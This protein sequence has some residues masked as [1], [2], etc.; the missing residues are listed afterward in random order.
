MKTAT[1]TGNLHR[2]TPREFGQ[3][4][5]AARKQ[6]HLTQAQLAAMAGVPRQRL[7]ALE[8]GSDGVSLGAYAKVI[9]ALGM[10]LTLK[11][12]LVRLA[13]YPQLQMLAWN[14]RGQEYIPE[15]EAFALYE[16]NWHHVDLNQVST[17][18]QNLIQN[19]TQQYG[20]GVLH[21]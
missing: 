12:A 3:A 9:A 11:P 15:R 7:I 16:R 18:E 21:V 17:Q 6:E 2:R 1:Q 8:K 13:D 19:L 20:R 14:R 4:L 5:R 10:E